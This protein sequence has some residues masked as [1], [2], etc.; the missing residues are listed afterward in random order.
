MPYLKTK[1]RRNPLK[2]GLPES[3]LRDEIKNV[4]LLG[5]TDNLS[6]ASDGEVQ[7]TNFFNQI[8]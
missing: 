3:M 7:V 6:D 5:L 1:Y 8:L 2:N 4:N